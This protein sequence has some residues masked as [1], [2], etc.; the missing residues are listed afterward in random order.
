LQ[1]ITQLDNKFHKNKN[2][3]FFFV[4]LPNLWYAT[5]NDKGFTE[6]EFMIQFKAKTPN[7]I[8]LIPSLTFTPFVT[9]RNV[10]PTS[11]NWNNNNPMS[12]NFCYSSH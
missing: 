11:L 1:F 10:L 9:S 7:N 3:T 8:F 12:S 2:K 6:N 5:I 4:L